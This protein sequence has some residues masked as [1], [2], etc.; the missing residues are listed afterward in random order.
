MEDYLIRDVKT[1]LE[2]KLE[3]KT[4]E[5]LVEEATMYM[6]TDAK[7]VLN[8]FIDHFEETI[9]GYTGELVFEIIYAQLRVMYETK[10]ITK[11]KSRYK[12]P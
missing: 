9:K 6:S 3:E 1:F 2:Y 7:N 10:E 11:I 8:E 4:I 12:N 5:L